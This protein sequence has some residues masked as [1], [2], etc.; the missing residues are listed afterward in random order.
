M[1]D[2]IFH[3]PVK[4]YIY[5]YNGFFTFKNVFHNAIR[6]AKTFCNYIDV[7]FNISVK[8]YISK[9]TIPHLNAFFTAWL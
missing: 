5:I 2:V 8:S 3:I 4:S 7:T 9:V 1:R 6:K